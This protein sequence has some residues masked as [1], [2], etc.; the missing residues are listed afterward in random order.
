[1]ISIFE[2]FNLNSIFA[3]KAVKI[4]YEIPIIFAEI[5]IP[6]AAFFALAK[7]AISPICINAQFPKNIAR[8]PPRKAKTVKIP[9]IIP[10]IRA[11]FIFRAA[12]FSKSYS[13]LTSRIA[14]AVITSP[15][16]RKISLAFFAAGMIRIDRI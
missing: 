16:S 9:K 10:K 1:M 8:I 15:R 6:V 7:L 13:S 12:F 3:I 14:L 11:I 2:A 4:K 5:I